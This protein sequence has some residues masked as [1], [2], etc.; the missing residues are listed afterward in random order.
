MRLTRMETLL[1]SGGNG[2]LAKKIL[3]ILEQNPKKIY[4]KIMV[5]NYGYGSD[6]QQQAC[7][8]K[9]FCEYIVGDIRDEM[10]V[11]SC[12]D[13]VDTVIHLAALKD[14]SYC[15]KNPVDAI[16]TN[17]EGSINLLKNFKGSKFL[18]VSTNKAIH[19]ESCYGAT[20]LL[21]EKIIIG[22]SVKD[23][24]K[25]FF[26]VRPGN[27]LDSD[28]GV[29]SIW[30][31]QIK[32]RNEI[33]LTNPSMTR[34]CINGIQLANFI[35]QT[36]NQDKTGIVYIPQHSMIQMGDLARAIIEKY[37]NADT[38]IKIIGA[39]P[40]EH[41]H[42]ILSLPQDIVISDSPD[43]GRETETRKKLTFPEVKY[44]VSQIE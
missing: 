2:F 34:F 38:K 44:L 29:I 37:G 33:E 12:L 25:K 16:R 32:T 24:L 11:K 14:I 5:R 7:F 27:I 4:I 9:G 17:I 42:D 21:M 35:L 41:V 23:P 3:S 30:K 39:R 6:S 36:L 26:I 18:A 31:N 1:I 40:G 22:E 15:E 13:E 28:G 20:K 19:P 43:A 8:S 10:F